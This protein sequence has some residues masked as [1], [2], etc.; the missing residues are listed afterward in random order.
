MAGHYVS[1]V[2]LAE[3]RAMYGGRL[4]PQD[5]AALLGCRSVGAVGHRLPPDT[6]PVSAGGKRHPAH[7]G[8]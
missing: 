2:I 8:D 1:N 5:L 3:A 6:G 4:T 7:P